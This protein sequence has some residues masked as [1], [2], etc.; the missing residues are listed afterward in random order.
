MNANVT[1]KQAS[2]RLYHNDAFGNH[3]RVWPTI[4]SLLVDDFEGQVS[5]RTIGLGGGGQA[6]YNVPVNEVLQRVGQM[7]DHVIANESAPDDQLL[8]QGE[9]HQDTGPLYIRA[10]FVAGL[11]MRD[12]MRTGAVDVNGLMAHM[13]LQR[14]MT[15]ASLADT[16]ALL[17]MFPGAVIETSVYRNP[18]GNCPGRNAVIWEVRQ[19]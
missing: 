3:L 8:W 4:D 19:Y 1:T 6:F 14:T 7:R 5:L 17:E 12:A 13:L 10:S 16:Q 2:L 15:P 9:L 18:L 11:K